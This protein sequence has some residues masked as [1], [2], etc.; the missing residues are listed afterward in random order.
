MLENVNNVD[1]L[2]CNN[3][4][5]IRRVQF[6]S[7]VPD[8]S[9]RSAPLKI[10]VIDP[11]D[12]K[13]ISSVDPTKVTQQYFD[14]SVM[15]D[16]IPSWTVPVV[17]GNMYHVMWGNGIDFNNMGVIPRYRW[18]STDK[19]VMFRMNNTRTREL[20]ESRVYYGNKVHLSYES[21][22]KELGLSNDR[23]AKPELSGIK[24]LSNSGNSSA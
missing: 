10:S 16:L 23:K 13:N 24:Q 18:K 14:A 6:F 17:T 20:F 12:N 4:V 1:T 22:R 11:A 7:M 19:G 15:N 3:Q 5:Q 9:F 21:E 8:T 2:V